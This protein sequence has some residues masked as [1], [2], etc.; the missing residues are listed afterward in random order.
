MVDLCDSDTSLAQTVQNIARGAGITLMLQTDM[1]VCV[2]VHHFPLLP[3]A[4]PL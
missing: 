4:K 2:M 3:G 1:N